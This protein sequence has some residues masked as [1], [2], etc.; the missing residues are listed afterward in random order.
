MNPHAHHARQ[1]GRDG[2]GVLV[3][4]IHLDLV[5]GLHAGAD[6]AP[7]HVRN[8]LDQVGQ[9]TNLLASRDAGNNVAD[10]CNVCVFETWTS[11]R[12]LTLTSVKGKDELHPPLTLKYNHRANDA[13]VTLGGL[14]AEFIL[15]HEACRRDR[16]SKAEADLHA[17]AALRAT[18]LAAV[19]RARAHAVAADVAGLSGFQGS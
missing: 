16:L 13:V 7:D 12:E 1:R 19:P 9:L 10:A 15:D 18:L 5:L 6:R 2:A 8:A 3:T 17:Q 4:L 14:D 11:D